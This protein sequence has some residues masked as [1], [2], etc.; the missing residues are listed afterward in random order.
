M[1]EDK[2]KFN[3]I[4]AEYVDL[5]LEELY[6]EEEIDYHENKDEVINI[7]DNTE[8]EVTYNNIVYYV[9]CYRLGEHDSYSVRIYKTD[10]QELSDETEV[11]HCYRD[12]SGGGFYGENIDVCDENYNTLDELNSFIEDKLFNNETGLVKPF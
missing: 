11:C 1:T 9:E 12:S 5:T 8:F 3:L 2:F 10:A 6:D 7:L 4:K